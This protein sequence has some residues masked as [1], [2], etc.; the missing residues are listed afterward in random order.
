MWIHATYTFNRTTTI[1]YVNGGV[2][3]RRGTAQTDGVLVP[4]DNTLYLGPER[5]RGNDLPKYFNSSMDEL[6]IYNR[7]L[8]AEDITTLMDME[9]PL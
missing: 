4:L 6:Y 1:D 9:K 5:E 8:T 3:L 7:T 2:N